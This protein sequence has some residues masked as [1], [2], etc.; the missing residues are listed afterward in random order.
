MIKKMEIPTTAFG[1]Y[2]FTAIIFRFVLRPTA[3]S[4]FGKSRW[5]YVNKETGV[6][7]G[8]SASNMRFYKMADPVDNK[9]YWEGRAK[10]K[11]Q[12][13]KTFYGRK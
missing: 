12:F 10:V 13:V 9:E 2:P 5:V 7:V 8:Y 1:L 3:D 4:K 6:Q 11:A